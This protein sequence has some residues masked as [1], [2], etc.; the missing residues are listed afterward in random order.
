MRKFSWDF[1]KI[2]NKRG[3]DARRITVTLKNIG[4]VSANWRFKFPNDSEIEMEPW[5]DA[6]TPTQEQAFEQLVLEQQIFQVEPRM[7]SLQPG[8]QMDLT[9]MYF[10]KEVMKHHL[11]VCFEVKNG[12]PLII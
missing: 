9:V 6:G 4:G 8:Q 2:P 3:K 10:P 12:K 11:N 5:V 1:G 7:G